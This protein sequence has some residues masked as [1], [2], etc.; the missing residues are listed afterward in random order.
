MMEHGSVRMNGHL[1][2]REYKSKIV[3]PN[4]MCIVTQLMLPDMK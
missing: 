2:V 1:P 4:S 3:I